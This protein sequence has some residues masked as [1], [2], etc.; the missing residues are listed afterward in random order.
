MDIQNWIMAQ[1][2]IDL[3][4]VVVLLWFIRFNI[5]GKKPDNDLDE[6]IRKSE[7]VLVQMR[8]LSL[9]LERNLEE[10][11]RQCLTTL[12]QLEEADEKAEES[13]ERIKNAA[14]DIGANPE[15]SKNTVKSSDQIRSSVNA[16]IAKGMPREEIAQ[17]LG[18]SV[19]EI[20]LLI[21]LQ[22]RQGQGKLKHT[23]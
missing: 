23:A 22:A 16:L 3:V 5:K 9:S 21:K 13:Y 8:E 11:R 1:M 12:D 6:K 7:A 10:K 20:D 14:R 4:I 17:H 19:D 18:M 15:R 2:G